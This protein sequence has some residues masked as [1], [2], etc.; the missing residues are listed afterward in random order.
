MYKDKDKQRQAGRDR[1]RRYR[2]K[3]KSVTS[4]GVTQGVTSAEPT[5]T[6]RPITG[7]AK[8]ATLEDYQTHPERYVQRVH[9]E[10]LNWTGYMTR[11]ELEQAGLKANRVPIPGDWDYEGVAEVMQGATA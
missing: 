3:A 6:R 5:V 7:C 8:D 4:G 9:P 11:A 1:Q 2:D 10:R